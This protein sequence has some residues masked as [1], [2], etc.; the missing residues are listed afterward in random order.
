MSKKADRI[1]SPMRGR[2]EPALGGGRDGSGRDIKSP[3]R[4]GGARGEHRDHYHHHK[5]GGGGGGHGK[6]SSRLPNGRGGGGGAGGGGG[7]GGA[8]GGGREK[9]AWA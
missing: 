5:A 8:G 4:T 6:D 7:G 1:K 9:G 3:M 2:P